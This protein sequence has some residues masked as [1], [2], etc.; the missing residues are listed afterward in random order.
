MK[1]DKSI[2]SNLNRLLSNEL[3]AVNQY[4]LHSKIFK[5]WGLKRLNDIE[6]TEFMDELKHADLY[7]ERI[8]FLEGSPIIRSINEFSICKN[9][10]DILR[11]DLQIEYN[12][13]NDLKESIKN[14]DLAQDYVSKKIMT[15]VLCD[16]E[17][18]VGFLETELA[19]INQIGVSNYMQS[20]MNG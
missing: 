4:F 8:L 19:L 14:A 10:E 1:G 3:I 7:I 9:V 17:K 2:I 6:H 16:E 20:Q 5:N 11:M 15:K 12:G 13:I 18:H